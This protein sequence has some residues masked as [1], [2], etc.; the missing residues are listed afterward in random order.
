M[1]GTQR[2][3]VIP[4]GTLSF[5]AAALLAFVYLLGFTQA[6]DRLTLNA[7]FRLRGV[8]ATQDDI[9]LVKLDQD[10]VDEYGF[11]IGEL[12]RGFYARALDNL[13][14]AGARVIGVDLFFPE[15]SVTQGGRNPDMELAAAVLGNNVVLPQVRTGSLRG[16]GWAGD[17]VPF[18]PLLRTARRGVLNLDVTA[19]EIS[20]EVTFQEGTLPS[21][22][23]AVLRAGE[24][25][26]VRLPGA[27][28]IDYRGPS[29]TFPALSFLDVYRNQFSYSRVQGRIVLL[30]VSLAGTD[31]D[32]V[33][34]P[35]GLMSGLEVNA[36]AVYTLLH[37]QLAQLPAPLYALLLLLSGVAWTPL[38]RRKWGLFHAL[39][40]AVLL[41]GASLLLFGLAALFVPPVWLALVPLVAYLGSSYRHLT[42]LD[43]QLSQRLG[44]LLDAAMLARPGD[45]SAGDLSTGFAPKGY[46]THAPEMLESLLQGLGGES[47]LLLLDGERTAHGEVSPVLVA[48]LDASVSERRRVST[49]TLPY[50]VAQPIFLDDGVVGAVA[51]SLPA[52]L[53]PHLLSL[54]ETSA[55]MFSQLARYQRLRERTQ[56]LADTLWPWRARSSLAKLNSLAMI[57]DLL[58]TE[59][60]WLGSLLETLPQAT[61]IMSPYGYS[62]FENAG[63]RRLFSGEKN[64][65][66]ALPQALQLD[67]ERFQKDYVT[68]VERGEE[69]ELGL[70]ERS[71]G[72]PV[73]LT[74]RVVRDS[75]EGGGGEVRGVA[76]IV[77]DL[78]KVEEMARQRQELIG[79]VVH[80]LRSP[81]TSIQGFA[82]LLLEGDMT[83]AH[84][85]LTIIRQE[86]ARMQR[87]TDTFLD[88]VKLESDAFRPE[89]TLSNLA[90]LLRYAVAA[91]STQ[92]AQK[93]IVVAVDAPPFLEA[94]V[95][96]DMISRLITNLLSNAVK[97]SPA[98]TRVTVRL[99]ADKDEAVLSVQ[100]EGYGMSEELR[101]QLFQKYKRAPSGKARA[102]KGTGLGLYLVRLI[103]DAHDGHVE[104]ASELDQGST[105]TVRLPLALE[106]LTY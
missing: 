41:S 57:G 25:P 86:A 38:T 34:T 20:S 81:L 96:P 93:E 36:N 33:A 50:A 101:A 29:G 60:S 76:G 85:P 40:G 67:A 24:L 46:V 78:S 72:R 90:E 69:L 18:N 65:L 32:Q 21:F 105:F 100:D 12:D 5:V 23:L 51:L 95:D 71:S 54:L 7:W 53:P 99:E 48:L 17:Y 70:V 73:L 3:S 8:Q 11:R 45:P 102:V 2:A 16:A 28:L 77:N 27:Y 14:A 61:F 94:L 26:N 66:R 43:H 83:D 58:A 22:A 44:G 79:V 89:R 80:D 6:V 74:L 64:M 62:V 91:V 63:A 68:L 87:M 37:G 9:L 97:Y 104:V 30:G 55:G 56:T 88:V 35:F 31:Q 4:F 82:D 98:A 59:R 92:A 10:F 84:E 13:S 47:G 39:A 103:V 49:G 1:K 106:A 42:T 52:P 19:Y 15:R 75:K